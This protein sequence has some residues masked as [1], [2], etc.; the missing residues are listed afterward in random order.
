M[1][2]NRLAGIV[3]LILVLIVG[4]SGRYGE[5]KTQAESDARDTEK[6]LLNNWS[7]YNV[8]VNRFPSVVRLKGPSGT[9]AIVFD[10]KNDDREILLRGKWD[11]VKDQKAWAEIVKVNTTSEGHFDISAFGSTDVGYS[12][13]I[14]E[15]WGTD[16][17][18]YGFIISRDRSEVT[19]SKVDE[20]S[21][22]LGWNSGGRGG[23]P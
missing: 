19:V 20:K 1:T 4:C 5:V 8:Y 10:P 13:R 16:K 3:F 15:I 17:Q 21:I 2:I 18:L 9:G 14:R 7:E 22:R 12:T 23:A 6:E 11:T